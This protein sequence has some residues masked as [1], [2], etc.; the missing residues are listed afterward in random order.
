MDSFAAAP[1]RSR[2]DGTAAQLA[3]AFLVDAATAKSAV[4]F[5]SGGAAAAA[6]IRSNSRQAGVIAEREFRAEK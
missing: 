6:A 5:W 4:D 2:P 3:A 1:T